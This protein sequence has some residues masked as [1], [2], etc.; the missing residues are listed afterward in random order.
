MTASAAEGPLAQ[1]LPKDWTPLTKEQL[2]QLS[3]IDSP[4]IANAIE[5]FKVIPRVQGYVG[6]GVRN[7]AKGK[8]KAMVAYAVTVR[9]DST[10]EY[11]TERQHPRLYAAIHSMHQAGGPENPLPV[12]VVIDDDGDPS[13][14]DWASHVGE[15][16]ATTFRRCGAVGIITDGGVRDID[17]IREMGDLWYFARGLVVAHGRP[18]IYDIGV[19]AN[20]NG[21]YV[22]TG[23]LIHADENGVIVIP[24][25]IADKI[26]QATV[27]FKAM[28]D[29]MLKQIK[30]PDF[31][32][33]FEE[34]S[35]YK[36]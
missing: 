22:R 10:S 35:T 9:G 33:Q 17:E 29:E 5:T 13:R 12:A 14:L 18:T 25:E 23:D 36:G 19:P 16:M 28:E 34:L 26:Y 24:R 30:S 3:T 15:I 6:T 1:L 27:D 20:I 32:K 4:S 11:K 31:F 8:G 2:E 21:M 7:L